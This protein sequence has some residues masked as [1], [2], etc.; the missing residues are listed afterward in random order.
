MSSYNISSGHAP[1]GGLGCGAVGILNE[2][3]EARKVKDN[4]ISFLKDANNTVYDC[5]C[6]VNASASKVLDKILALCNAHTV[7]RDI[8]IHL[9]CGRKDPTGDDITGGV[10]VLIYNEEMK[11]D[12]KRVA[13]E[14]AK[15]FGYRL[16]SDSTTPKGYEGVKIQ[17][18]LRFL[19][20]TKAKAMLIECCFVD[21]ADDA[22]VWNPERCAKAI[23]KG[24]T[25]Q[26]VKENAPQAPTTAP[27]S[28]SSI[29]VDYAKSFDA[30]F[31]GT[32]T[33]TSPDGILAMRA[34]ANTSK[35]L[36]ANAKT[37]DK[38]RCY[39]YYTKEADGTVWL[40][41]AYNGH[42][43]FMSKGYLR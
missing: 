14:I 2:S 19:N 8:S 22:E 18:G 5:T 26:V 10:E 42:T 35:Q 11:E 15:E 1:A 25:G 7:D 38:V 6:N 3:N 20:G 4:L 37:G 31:A 13:D 17:P 9:N 36:I 41:V 12:A 21:D 34:G 40:L 29:K 43:G 23:F 28:N 32:Y 33:V 27:A 30:K 16:R 39:G 24:L